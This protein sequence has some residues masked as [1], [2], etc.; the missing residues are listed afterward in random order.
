MSYK[1][2]QGDAALLHSRLI[3][4]LSKPLL[5]ARTGNDGA[6]ADHMQLLLYLCHGEQ[7][8]AAARVSSAILLHTHDMVTSYSEPACIQPVH[9]SSLRMQ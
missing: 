2:S 5:A 7:W 8:Q 4:F 1:T 3:C 9:A 6:A